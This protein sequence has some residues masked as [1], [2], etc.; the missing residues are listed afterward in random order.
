ML[1]VEI[2]LTDDKQDLTH[3]VIK[4]ERTKFTKPHNLHCQFAKKKKKK[5]KKKN[6][7]VCKTYLWS[8]ERS[9]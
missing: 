6:Q 8:F 9:L 1:S 3:M 2:V 5:E 7:I 4:Y